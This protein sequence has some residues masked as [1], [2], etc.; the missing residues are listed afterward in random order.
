MITEEKHKKISSARPH[1]AW[2]VSDGWTFNHTTAIP[3]GELSDREPVVSG[4]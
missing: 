1:Y 2:F 3:V 4:Q